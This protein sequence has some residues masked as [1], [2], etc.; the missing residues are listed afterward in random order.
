MI[1]KS[2]LCALHLAQTDPQ[3]LV[4][5]CYD[6]DLQEDVLPFTIIYGMFLPQP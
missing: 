6:A 5:V 2:L 3:G 4:Y 1:S